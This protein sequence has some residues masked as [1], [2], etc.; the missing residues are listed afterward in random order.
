MHELHRRLADRASGGKRPV[1]V[2]PYRCWDFDVWRREHEVGRLPRL[3]V[4]GLPSWQRLFPRHSQCSYIQFIYLDADHAGGGDDQ[5]RVRLHHVEVGLRVPIKINVPEQIGRL[6]LNADLMSN[7]GLPVKITRA[8]MKQPLAS[9]DVGNVGVVGPLLDVI[10]RH[11][12]PPTT[13]GRN[14]G[15]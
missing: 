2:V 5:P 7:T 9:A 13:S 14:S 6:W 12:V 10:S 3:R 1:C 4:V 11:A 8:E 15:R